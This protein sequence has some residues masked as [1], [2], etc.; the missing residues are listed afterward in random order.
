MLACSLAVT[1]VPGT[2]AQ[3]I[4]TSGVLAAA[5]AANDGSITLR[6]DVPL[7]ERFAR[8]EV[9]RGTAADPMTYQSTLPM[10]ALTNPVFRGV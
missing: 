3:L 1:G 9:R 10:V 2:L 7:A 8:V 5:V 4:G 6:F